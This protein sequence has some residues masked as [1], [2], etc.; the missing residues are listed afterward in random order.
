MKKLTAILLA[1]VMA[2][3]AGCSQKEVSTENFDVN[4]FYNSISSMTSEELVSLDDTYISNYYGINTADLD[5][6]VFAQSENPNSAESVI[7]FKCGDEAKRGEYVQAVETAIAQKADELKNYNQPEQAK[8]AEDCQ[9]G[10]ADVLV[11]AIIS[12]NSEEINAALD[13]ELK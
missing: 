11:Y 12:P 13:A 6:Y 1:A 7:I 5:G 2:F 10:Q 3:A 8:L 9:V 4:A